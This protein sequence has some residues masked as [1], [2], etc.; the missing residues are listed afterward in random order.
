MAGLHQPLDDG[1]G[2]LTTLAGVVARTWSSYHMLPFIGVTQ[3]QNIYSLQ[4]E[5]KEI[6]SCPRYSAQCLH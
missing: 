6:Q 2:Q 3:N 4:S 5:I 1:G